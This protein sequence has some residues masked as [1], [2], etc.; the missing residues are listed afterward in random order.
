MQYIFR[1]QGLKIYFT[2]FPSHHRECLFCTPL[3]NLSFSVSSISI[4]TWKR[5]SV[6]VLPRAMPFLSVFLPRD[7]LA[8][9]TYMSSFHVNLHRSP[10][11]EVRKSHYSLW[12]PWPLTLSLIKLTPNCSSLCQ[13]VQRWQGRI[14][15]RHTERRDWFYT[16]G[17]WQGRELDQ[18]QCIAQKWLNPKIFSKSVHLD[19]LLPCYIYWKV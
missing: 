1:S 9:V 11:Q 12:R 10:Y 5:L 4:T 6:E 18:P 8:L 15:D 17:C 3:L 2:I 13:A 19:G 16:L 7:L 14:T